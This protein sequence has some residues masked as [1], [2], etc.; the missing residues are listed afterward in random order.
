MAVR[1]HATKEYIGQTRN[2]WSNKKYMETYENEN[3]PVSLGYSESGPKREVYSITGLPQ[4]ERSQ[5]NNLN[6]HLKELEKD[7]K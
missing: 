4:E 3:V 1:Q 7:S 6:L 2:Q 5:K